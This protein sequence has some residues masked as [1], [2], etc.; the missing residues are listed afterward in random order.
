[1]CETGAG[2]QVAELRDSYMVMVMMM[3]VIFV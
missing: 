2:Q 3:E 1:M